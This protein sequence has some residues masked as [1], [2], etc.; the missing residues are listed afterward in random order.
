M[1]K[2]VGYRFFMKVGMIVARYFGL[3]LRKQQV[4]SAI[5]DDF[6][7]ISANVATTG[8]LLFRP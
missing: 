1:L 6:G 4:S 7:T 5:R 3:D 8:A 2:A